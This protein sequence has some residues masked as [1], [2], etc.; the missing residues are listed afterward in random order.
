MRRPYAP[1][2]EPMT[3]RPAPP[4]WAWPRP[5][6]VFLG[7]GHDVIRGYTNEAMTENLAHSPRRGFVEP[8]RA[9]DAGYDRVFFRR[10]LS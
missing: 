10:R 1:Y 9:N 7:G 5:S 6:P 8:H 4:S 2:L 3:A